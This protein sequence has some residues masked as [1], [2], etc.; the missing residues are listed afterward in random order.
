MNEFETINDI[1]QNS[2]R[3]SSY[4]SVLISSCVFIIYTISIKIID[5]FKSKSRNKP[6]LEMTKAVTTVSDNVSKLN[7]ILDKYIQDAEKKEIEKIKSIIELSFINFQS[8]IE[9]LCR[10]I[11]I[12]NNIETNRELIISNINQTISTE[13]YKVYSNLSLYELHDKHISSY[14]KEK[15][16][17][18]ICNNLITIIYNGQTERTRITQVSNKLAILINDYSTYVYN[19]T[20]N[21]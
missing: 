20:F 8:K 7:I 9:H 17:E 14:L 13:Y 6:I 19:K 2:V 4:V 5:L 18:N 16:I 10:N 12:N 1:V 15:W 11:I 21:D 3:N